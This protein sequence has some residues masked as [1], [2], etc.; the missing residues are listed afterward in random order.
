MK[1]IDAVRYKTDSH[2]CEV[3]SELRCANILNETG[4]VVYTKQQMIEYINRNPNNV[5][6]KYFKNNM[7]I[8]GEY[9][10]VVDNAYL[11]TDSNNI[12]QD[13]LGELPT[14]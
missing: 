3:I 12:K 8:S 14:F 7:W 5:K 11:R 10:R 4:K 2:G 13:N 9:V 1:Y 6:T